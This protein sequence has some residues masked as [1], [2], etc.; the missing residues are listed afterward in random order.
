MNHESD[1]V[2]M[3]R[4]NEDDVVEDVNDVIVMGDENHNLN[5]IMSCSGE[6]GQL[7]GN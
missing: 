2:I 1:D 7:N 4:T 6:D 5:V 3:D